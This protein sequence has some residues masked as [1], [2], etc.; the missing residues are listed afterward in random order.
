VAIRSFLYV[1]GNEPRKL[2]KVGTFGSDAVIIDL[3]D[4]VPIKQKVET[5]TAVRQSIPSVKANGCLVYVR[6]NPTSQ[7]ADFSVPIGVG[8]LE[9]VVCADLDGIVVPK[10]ES[11]KELVQIDTIIGI[12]ERNLGLPELS[13]EIHPIVETALGMWNAFEIAH[14]SPRIKSLHLG[15]GDFTR[16]V[17]IELSKDESEL[18]YA[19]SR[20]VTISKVCGLNPPPDIVWLH[21]E[22][23]QGFIESVKRGKRMGFFGKTCIHPRQ[24]PIVNQ[25]YSPNAEE[26]LRAQNIVTAFTDAEARGSASI[27]VDGVFVDYP[28]AEK[29]EKVLQLHR[30]IE[31]RT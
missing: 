16:D 24:I 29:A 18:T 20:L 7:K 5:R 27:V 31:K 4:A 12:R 26:V 30:E 22:D 3:E 19:R 6:I 1:P 13:I 9:E 17:N 8:D 15:A 25:V 21:M 10:V 11:A 2:N 14:S 28:V 23:E